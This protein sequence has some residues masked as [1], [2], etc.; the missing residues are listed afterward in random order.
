MKDD[1]QDVPKCSL[2]GYMHREDGAKCFTLR[3]PTAFFGG[4]IPLELFLEETK[5]G[6]NLVQ[7]EDIKEGVNIKRL[8]LPE[9]YFDL[10]FDLVNTDMPE[11]QL[12]HFWQTEDGRLELEPALTEEEHA[13]REEAYCTEKYPNGVDF[14]VP[15]ED[16]LEDDEVDSY[17]LEHRV[18]Q[19]SLDRYRGKLLPECITIGD[20]TNGVCRVVKSV[21]LPSSFFENGNPTEINFLVDEKEDFHPIRKEDISEGMRIR[22]IHVPKLYFNGWYKEYSRMLHD[23]TRSVDFYYVGPECPFK[24]LKRDRKYRGQR[25]GQ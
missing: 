18:W 13:R 16:G 10:D 11:M 14:E 9:D 17:I 7:K 12:L 20:D 2:T 5:D 15:W 19:R 24:L 3:L 8:V 23:P 21:R 1:F 25:C 6:F 4:K 22:T